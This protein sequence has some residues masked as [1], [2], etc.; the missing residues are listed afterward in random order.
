MREEGERA[1]P[2]S[3]TRRA[4]GLH[5][6]RSEDPVR[7]AAVARPDARGRGARCGSDKDAVERRTRPRGLSDR[8]EQAA[9]SGAAAPRAAAP[10]RRP[11]PPPP[12][13]R[14]TPAALPPTR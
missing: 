4:P 3:L 14:C 11:T 2:S 13:R 10:S 9:A 7:T 6:P 12:R 8:E 1:P 5:L